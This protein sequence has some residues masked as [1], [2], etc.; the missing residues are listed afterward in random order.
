MENLD[1]TKESDFP[2]ISKP[3]N[4]ALQNAGI[5]RLEQLTGTT[6]SD[7]LKLHG[8]GPKGVRILKDALNEK[9][10]SFANKS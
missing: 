2:K 3:A 10:L 9:G 6:E 7:I 8:M 1:K 4:R 5:Y